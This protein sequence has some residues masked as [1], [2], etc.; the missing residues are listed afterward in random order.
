MIVPNEKYRVKGESKYFAK[1]YGTPNPI[2][3]VEDTDREVFGKSWGVM[4]GNP[5][6]LL[7][8][9]RSGTEGLPLGGAVYYGH[10]GGYGELVHES[11]LEPVAEATDAA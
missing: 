3:R 2:I 7:Y 11:E 9:M 8:A 6:C 10:I 4:D 5:T 1:K